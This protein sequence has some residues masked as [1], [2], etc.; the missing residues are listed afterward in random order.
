[1]G[2]DLLF[3]TRRDILERTPPV[4]LSDDQLCGSSGNQCS[5]VTLRSMSDR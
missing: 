4:H 5:T 1:M 3:C 2:T